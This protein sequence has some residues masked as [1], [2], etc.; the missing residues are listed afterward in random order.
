VTEPRRS[1]LAL[2]GR[3]VPGVRA[4]TEQIPRFAAAWAEE[5]E[6]ALG[7][8]GPLLAVL[9]DSTAQGIGAGSHLTGWAGQLRERLAVHHGTEWGVANW[10]RSGARVA[11]VVAEQLPALRGAGRRPDLVVCAV[12]ANDVFWG[13]TTGAAR[14]AFAELLPG[15]PAPAVVATVPE[16][17]V[18]GRARRLNAELRG[19]A[20]AHG[21]AVAEVARTIR[22]GRGTLASDG[23]HPSTRGYADWTAAFA[24]ALALPDPEVRG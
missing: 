3:F 20:A 17:G 18:A 14:R 8:P 9:G 7:A 5:T 15:L 1:P 19:L 12:G 23:F 11:D 24:A 4:V 22:P 16:G 10:S 6:R 21:V 13:L 2:L